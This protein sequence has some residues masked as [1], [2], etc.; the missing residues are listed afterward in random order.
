MQDVNVLED[1]HL[2]VYA[3]LPVVDWPSAGEAERRATTAAAGEAAWRI[4]ADTYDSEES[5][6]EA[7]A[8]FAGTVD[9]AQVRALV[10]GAWPEAYETG[11]AQVVEALLAA[12]DRMPALRGIFVGDMV[13]EECEISWI[14]QGDLTPLLTGFPELEHFGIRG[15]TGLLFPPV[16]HEKL[17]E[18]VVQTGGL[19]AEAVR[20]IAAS[21][22]PALTVLDLWLG[23]S[24]YG[25]DSG[26]ADLAPFL[27]GTRLPALRRLALRNS[28][29]QDE[30]AAAVATAPVVARL[31]ALDLSMGVLT[32]AGGTA[33]LDGVPLT[34]LASLDLHHNYL[35]ADVAQRLRD[36]LEPAG[37]RLDLD[38]GDADE[39]VDGD[40]GTVWRY[41]AVGE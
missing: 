10:V 6:P 4:T 2:T 36:A 20:G 18:L 31:S 32:D 41:V 13:S 22:F 8:R 11:P 38:R 37:V 17:R 27:A 19:P 16:R 5:W 28:E 33:L 1:G 29:I 26:P 35:G 39:D 24:D 30:V 9:L 14:V 3:G 12:R 7:F 15:G 34:H 40:D 21:D 23:T 25:G